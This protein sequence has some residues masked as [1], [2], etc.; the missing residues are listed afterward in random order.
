VAPRSYRAQPFNAR[1][2]IDQLLEEAAAGHFDVRGVRLLIHCLR[3]GGGR[4]AELVLPRKPTGFRPPS[5]RH[6]VEPETRVSA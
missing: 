4:A 2:A 5:N 6:G 1:G 3:G